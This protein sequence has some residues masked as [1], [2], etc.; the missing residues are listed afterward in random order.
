MMQSSPSTKKNT[1]VKI[2]ATIE[3]VHIQTN[4]QVRFKPKDNGKIICT[5]PEFN[6]YYSVKNREDIVKKGDAFMDVFFS[7][8]L[9]NGNKYSL[10]KLAV[11]LYSLGFRPQN[12]PN[13]MVNLMRNNPD[14][15][16][17][18]KMP[19]VT[20]PKEFDKAHTVDRTTN[21]AAHA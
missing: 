16:T 14:P 11:N 1:M 3:G 15:S 7:Y 12:N 21:F 17:S 8:Y 4:Y 6:I 13:A 10:K 20:L 9:E 18:F 19:G 5:I 2:K